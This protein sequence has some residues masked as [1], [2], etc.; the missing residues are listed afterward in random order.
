M[1]P[2]AEPRLARLAAMIAE[3]ARAAMLSYLLDGHL[4]SA[5][6]LAAAA[7]VGAPTASAHLAKLHDAG[8]RLATS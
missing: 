8:S 5:G 4:A 7:S 2:R 1:A 3:P 6:E